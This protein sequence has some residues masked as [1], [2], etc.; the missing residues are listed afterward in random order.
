MRFS[1]DASSVKLAG[2][3]KASVEN[4]ASFVPDFNGPVATAEAAP[5]YDRMLSLFE[6]PTKEKKRAVLIRKCY[7]DT[8][9]I[10]RQVSVE[11]EK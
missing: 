6:L 3:S 2:V 10:L 8:T 11:V 7:N 5:K 1:R 9:V 4:P